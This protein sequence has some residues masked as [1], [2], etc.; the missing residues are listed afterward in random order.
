[1]ESE[2]F[3]I[4]IAVGVIATMLFWVRSEK[5]LKLVFEFTFTE[6]QKCKI[7][8]IINQYYTPENCDICDRYKKVHKETFLEP[9]FKNC[10]ARKDIKALKEA[11]ESNEEMFKEIEKIIQENG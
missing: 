11:E 5:N 9:P 1:M 10:S 6:E 8:E 4:G 7:K 2:Y 3:I